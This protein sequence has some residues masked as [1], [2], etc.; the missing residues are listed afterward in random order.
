[1]ALVNKTFTDLASLARSTTG[2]YFDSSG[3]LQIGAINT[4]R[5]DYDPTTLTANGLLI[6]PAATNLLTFSEQMDNAVWSKLRCSVSIN[7]TSAPNGTLTA[8]KIVED[9]S[10]NQLHPL[11]RSPTLNSA[12]TYYYS[13]FVKAAGRNFVRLTL[14]S[15]ITTNLVADL[16]LTTG[17]YTATDVTRV[18]VLNCGNGWYRISGQF[19]TIPVVVGTT[20]LFIYP[21]ITYGTN[22]YTGDGV[23]GLYIWGMQLETS[24]TPTSYIP[25]TTTSVTRGAD[26]LTIP[27]ST[28]WQGT[29]SNFNIDDDV[30]ITSSMD[31]SGIVVSGNGYV[32]SISYLPNV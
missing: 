7:A 32:R 14:S 20:L 31:S 1:M 25:T 21:C 16:D 15:N 10:T 2:T 8:D 5:F 6:E 3:I 29:N 26:V 24:N 19:T 22:I 4:P 27:S 18:S 30:G 12:T 11:F 17:N 23:S 13:F 28:G 9:S